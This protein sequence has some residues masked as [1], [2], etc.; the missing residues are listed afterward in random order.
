MKRNLSDKSSTEEIRIRFDADVARFSDLATGQAA[1]IDA[2]LVM[3]LITKAAVAATPSIQRVLDIG[4]G[5]G[6]NTIRLLREYGQGFECDLCDLSKPMLDKARERLSRETTA[7]VRTYHGDFRLMECVDN[8]Y[9]VVLAAAVLHH[10]RDDL[11]WETTFRKIHRIIRPGGSVWISDLVSHENDGIRQMMWNRYGDTLEQSGGTTY[12]NSVFDYI[13]RE[14]SPRSLTY[15]LSL[16][17]DVGFTLVEVLHKNSCFAAFGA[18]KGDPSP[19]PPP[20]PAT[21]PGSGAV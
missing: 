2:P 17:R 20:S 14:D 15:Q 9:D 8:T 18:I 3:E 6:N 19:T 5:A 7:P 12:R 1:T 4:C 21:G 10:L 16:L 11:D 13:D